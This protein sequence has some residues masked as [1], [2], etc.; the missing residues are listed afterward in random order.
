MN[1]T[2]ENR[3][4][5]ARIARELDEIANR[6]CYKCP[7]CGEII[8]FDNAQYNQD[9]EEYT[10]QECGK[11]FP[12]DELEAYTVCDWLCDAL[13]IE[14]TVSSRLDYVAARIYVALG[15]PT[16]WIDTRDNAAHLSWGTDTAWYPLDTDTA[17]A[18]DAEAEECYD[19]ARGR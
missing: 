4:Y 3:E 1:E 6:D 18:V 10:C 16:V 7:E 19:M 13:D 11:T 17:A 12:E 15:G 14:Y 9:S 8:A 2:R 5:C